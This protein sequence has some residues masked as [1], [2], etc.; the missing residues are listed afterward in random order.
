[1]GIIA[2]V[3]VVAVLYQIFS[4]VDLSIPIIIF[5]CISGYIGAV[6]LMK[7]G[8][9]GEIT[10]CAV[11]AG[12]MLIL[13]PAVLGPILLVAAFFIPNKKQQINIPTPHIGDNINMSGSFNNVNVK[14]NL[15]DT[16]QK[17]EMMSSIDQSMK[18]DLRKLVAQLNDELQKVPE[19]KSADAEAVAEI[20]K[21][22]IDQVSKQQ[23]NKAM[24]DIGAEGLKKAAQNIASVA[25][26]VLPIA[27]QIVEQIGKITQMIPLR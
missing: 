17:I 11:V 9:L 15:Y 26:A 5:W 22:L 18:D 14:A 24:L 6:W 21:Q 20:A 27:I 4:V 19:G 7:K 25:P 8:Y 2:F 10:G 13:F 1:V 16:I 12:G 3:L 23:P